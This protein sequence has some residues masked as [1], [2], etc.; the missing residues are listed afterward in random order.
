LNQIQCW[1]AFMFVVFNSSSF[2]LFLLLLQQK[3]KEWKLSHTSL[4][5]L[6]SFHFNKRESNW[7]RRN[8]GDRFKA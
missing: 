2:F 6:F 4:S 8:E 3:K 1:R 7:S 5:S